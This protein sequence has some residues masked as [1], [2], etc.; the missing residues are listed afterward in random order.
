VT[1]VQ[2]CAFRS[3]QNPKTP[4]VISEFILKCL[5]RDNAHENQ[6]FLQST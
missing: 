6:G 4:I 5:A 1:G 3:P 2:T